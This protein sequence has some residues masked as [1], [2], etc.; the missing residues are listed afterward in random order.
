MKT[1]IF[2]PVFKTAMTHFFACLLVS[3]FGAVFMKAF[4][5]GHGVSDLAGVLAD[6]SS[7]FFKELFGFRD[8]VLPGVYAIGIGLVAGYFRTHK[9]WHVLIWALAVFVLIAFFLIN[10]DN[11]FAMY[12]ALAS[13]WFGIG[14]LVGWIISRQYWATLS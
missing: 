14:A 5:F 4:V 3:F 6:T 2:F 9:W 11:L 10:H 13:P 12:V 1:N 8:F 7:R